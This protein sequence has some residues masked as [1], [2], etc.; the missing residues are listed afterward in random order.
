VLAA[1]LAATGFLVLTLG[2]VA[3]TWSP[4]SLPV[5]AVALLGAALLVLGAGGRG[6]PMPAERHLAA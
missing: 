3:P 5:P 6:A 2:G 1:L 4:L